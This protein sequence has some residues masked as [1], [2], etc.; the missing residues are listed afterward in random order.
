MKL[1]GFMSSFLLEKMCA[2][3]KIDVRADNGFKNV[4]LTAVAKAL[5]DHLEP[6]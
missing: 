2:L 1:P 3:I 4:L 6:M 5:H